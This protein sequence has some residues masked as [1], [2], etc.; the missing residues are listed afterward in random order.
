[1]FLEKTHR[2]VYSLSKGLNGIAACSVFFMMAITCA[3]V[4]FRYFRHPITGT[5]ELV[6]LSGAVA[7]SFALA[8]TSLEKGHIAVDFIVRK[9]SEKTRLWVERVNDIILAVLFALISWHSF[10]LALSSKANNEGTMT[11]QLPF[12]PFII[13]ISVSFGLLFFICLLHF[14]LSFASS[15]GSKEAE[16][17]GAT[18]L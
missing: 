12:Y 16:P 13:G 14:M 2:F 3:D 15:D 18:C 4:I 11:L 6:G 17:G 10:I 1:M 8:Q 9:F 5:F 7:V